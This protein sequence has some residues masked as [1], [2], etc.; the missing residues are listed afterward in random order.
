MMTKTK[1]DLPLLLDVLTTHEGGKEL[2][3]YIP[4]EPLYENNKSRIVKGAGPVPCDIMFIGE[5]PGAEEDANGR[6]F[7]GDAGRCLTD[8]MIDAGINRDRMYITNLVKERP[9]ANRVPTDKEVRA[10]IPYLIEEI[11]KVKPRLIVTLG[12]PAMKAILGVSGV[13]KLHGQIFNSQEFGCK[14]VPLVHP[15]F[16]M[17]KAQTPSVRASFI[18]DLSR[19]RK[20]LD[21][22]AMSD[23]K[24]PTSYFLVD[25]IQKFDCL[26]GKLMQAEFVDF[27][28][29]TTSTDPRTGEI[30]CIGFSI[31]EHKA[32]VVPI[33]VDGKS[34][35]G[36]KDE[37]VK[38]GL[39]QFFESDVPKSCHAG[40]LID[41]P[42]VR[43]EGWNIRHYDADTII[44]DYLCDENKNLAQRGLKELAWE[45]TDM[46]GYDSE[47][48]QLKA[49]I[50]GPIMLDY[51]A[52]HK[53][54][55]E[56]GED[57][58][59]EPEKPQLSFSQIPFG[60]LW[61][62]CAADADVSGR[63]RRIYFEKLQSQNLLPLMKKI[64]MPA[65]MVLIKM[66]ERGVKPDLKVLEEIR[67]E[68]EQLMNELD[69]QLQSHPDILRAKRVLEVKEINFGSAPQLQKV[70]FDVLKI[71]PIK[72]SKKTGKPSTDKEVLEELAKTYEIPRLLTQRRAY[73][74]SMTH[75]G[76][77]F[78]A[79]MRDDA[80]IHTSYL[81]YGTETGRL[82]S[83]KPNLQNIPRPGDDERSEISGRIRNIFIAEPGKILIDADLKSIEWRLMANYSKDPVMIQEILDNV[84]IHSEN[85][86]IISAII[87]REVSRQ[88]AKNGTYAIGYGATG[89]R[90]AMMY[91]VEEEIGNEILQAIY[92]KYQGLAKNC[93]M[94]KISARQRG[95]VTNLFGRRRRLPAILSDDKKLRGHAERS[96]INSPVQGLAG[97]IMYAMMIRLQEIWDEPANSD[98]WMIMQ[99]HDS[100]THEVPVEKQEFA[101]ASIYREMTRPIPGITIPL[102]VEMKVGSSLGSLK[103]LSKEEI[104]AIVAR[105]NNP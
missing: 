35:W 105:Q 37:Y 34:Y 12:S 39:K 32:A 42:F 62:Y 63:L 50:L 100:L 89:Y 81:I 67:K 70:L 96:A 58:D 24:K 103:K 36:D 51:R 66:E 94:T 5:A 76:E 31:N 64:V 40:A 77:K 13:T 43:A 41:I 20:F 80:R 7:I 46:G 86:K 95:Y 48:E 61:P 19:V 57:P 4:E 59:T 22:G 26:I 25:N 29:E 38:T 88:D 104:A 11:R 54:W 44:M 102:E 9:P 55:K 99:T 97:D 53:E 10:Y 30:I 52:K 98:I 23:A 47:I 87:G 27:D 92:R 2:S 75:Y 79:S 65:Q 84:D 3:S 16:V 72:F 68:Y 45:H 8:C 74:H 69:V 1:S 78:L 6:P 73:K 21:T 18:N 28:L 56:A 85:A 15:S 14:I 90:L 82:A 49:K 17:R 91:G 93:D 33:W 71:K 83:R 60:T 101:I